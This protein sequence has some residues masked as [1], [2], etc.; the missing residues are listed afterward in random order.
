[1]GTP[2]GYNVNL[3][4]YAQ[5]VAPPHAAHDQKLCGKVV[6][7]KAGKLDVAPCLVASGLA[8]PYWILA[9]NAQDGYAIVSGGAPTNSAPGGCRTGTGVNDSGLWI[10]TRTQ[11]RDEN[12]VQKA[13]DIAASKGFDLSVLNDVDNTA[14]GTEFLI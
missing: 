13:R 10:L 14:C 4:N 9:Y 5:D 2:L 1:M 8:G 12:L 6:D 3:H 7:A 11:S